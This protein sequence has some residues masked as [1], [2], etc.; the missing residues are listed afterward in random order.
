MRHLLELFLFFTALM[1]LS[2]WYIHRNYILR[3]KRKIWH[4]IYWLPCLL[5]FI[6]MATVFGTYEPRPE[7]MS[8]LGLLLVIYL[9]KAI[10]LVAQLVKNL[11]AI[12]EI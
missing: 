9:F 5:L 2:D 7:A 4:R 12:E 3:L 11:P 1:A 8:R 6:G 10:S